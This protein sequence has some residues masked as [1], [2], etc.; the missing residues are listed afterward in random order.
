MHGAVCLAIFTCL[1][2]ALQRYFSRM[3]CKKHWITIEEAKYIKHIRQYVILFF[4][5]FTISII[6]IC[7]ILFLNVWIY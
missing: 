2:I 1:W 4:F 5:W 6:W 3:I 7:M